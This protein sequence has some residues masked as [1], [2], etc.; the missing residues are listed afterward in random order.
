MAAAVVI[1][2]SI[3]LIRL[4][5]PR[6]VLPPSPPPSPPSYDP[7]LGHVARVLDRVLKE[8]IVD[9]ERSARDAQHLFRIFVFAREGD[10]RAM[11]GQ[12]WECDMCGHNGS[13]MDTLG[14]IG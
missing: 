1:G 6:Q 8:V 3:L 14:R 5:P 2:E 13:V 10:D 12:E 4:S 11:H 9:R 7:P